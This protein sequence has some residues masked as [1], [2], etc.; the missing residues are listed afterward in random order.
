MYY[1][2]CQQARQLHNKYANFSL[3]EKRA[4][5]GV[6]TSAAGQMLGFLLPQITSRV[7]GKAIPV[8]AR[9]ALRSARARGIQSGA[10]TKT[11][12]GVATR[13]K[14]LGKRLDAAM[15]TEGGKMGWWIMGAPIAGQFFT[16]VLDRVVGNTPE[17]YSTAMSPPM[18]G[19][20]YGGGYGGGW[21]GGGYGGGWY[22]GGYG[23]GGYG[24]V[25]YER[26]Y[27]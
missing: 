20:G 6:L 18:Q 1:T 14:W 26:L 23:G 22:G 4:F 12:K 17:A 11:L 27:M 19:A 8:L 5:V 25:P 2:I 9:S 15:K 13:S 21:Y 7:A 10:L 3:Q 24:G 16:N